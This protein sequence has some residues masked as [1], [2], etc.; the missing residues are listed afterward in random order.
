[1]L[2]YLSWKNILVIIDKFIEKH[3]I[4]IRS[5]YGPM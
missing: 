3:N 5:C 2:V 1:M 4:V